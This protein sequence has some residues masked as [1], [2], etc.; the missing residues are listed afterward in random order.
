MYAEVESANKK[1]FHTLNEEFMSCSCHG[2]N[3]NDGCSSNIN[4]SNEEAS[5]MGKAL[6]WLL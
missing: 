6:C 4:D 5:I 3:H 1:H 2:E